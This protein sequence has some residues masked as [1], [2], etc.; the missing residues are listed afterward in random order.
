[1]AGSLHV[2]VIGQEVD[3]RLKRSTDPVV[4]RT[5]KGVV[6]GVLVEVAFFSKQTYPNVCDK[7]CKVSKSLF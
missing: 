2:R 6:C 5:Y 1:M 7:C 3:R 4:S